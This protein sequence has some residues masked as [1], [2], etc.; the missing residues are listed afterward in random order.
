[1]KLDKLAVALVQVWIHD[2][3]EYQ[4][5]IGTSHEEKR[6]NKMFMNASPIYRI[7]KT[8]GMTY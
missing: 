1:M 6:S 5:M 4:G 3:T 7:V 8:I 2:R